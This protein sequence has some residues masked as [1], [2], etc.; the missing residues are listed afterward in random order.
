VSIRQKLP[1]LAPEFDVDTVYISANVVTVNICIGVGP[2][3]D[4][5]HH[6]NLREEL[7]AMAIE[8]IRTGGIESLSLRA[9]TRDLG[10]SHAAPLRHFSSKADL[11]RAL[12][13]EGVKDMIS[14]IVD[15]T[16][17]YSGLHRLRKMALQYIAWTSANL[18]YHLVLRNPDVLKHAAADLRDDLENFAFVQKQAI[19]V[20][21]AEGWRQDEDPQMLFFHLVSLTAGT[22]I[23]TT[24][25]IYRVPVGQQPSQETIMKSFDLFLGLHE[26]EK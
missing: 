5:Y 6:G 2:L 8:K 10:V 21:Q 16:V 26:A 20:A 3:P 7:M 18:A 13:T 11:L 14:Q 1:L 4:T 22:A 15:T 25:P 23:V 9:L 17:E 19:E 12:A 24:D